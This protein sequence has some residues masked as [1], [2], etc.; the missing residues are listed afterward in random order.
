MAGSMVLG[1]PDLSSNG[2]SNPQ[3]NLSLPEGIAFD[4]NGNLWVADSGNCRVVEF[5][6]P[7]SNGKPVNLIIGQPNSFNGMCDV[8]GGM[9]RCPMLVAMDGQGDLFVSDCFAGL[10]EFKPPL[11]ISS[12]PI[13]IGTTADCSPGQQPLTASDICSAAGLAFDPAGNLWVADAGSDF[14]SG[15]GNRIVRLPPPFTNGADTVIG[16]GTFSTGSNDWCPGN[17]PPGPNQTG[18]NS[19]A[20]IALDGTFNLYVAD[21]NNS[22]ALQF[23]PTYTLNPPPPHFVWQDGEAAAFV[24]GQPNFNTNTAPTPSQDGISAP[25]AVLAP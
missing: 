6:Q 13:P 23:E 16:Q 7:F 15:K 12:A 24:F 11:T 8:L 22:R 17:C 4:S 10:N 19:P 20:G 3:N 1:Q 14:G 25:V 2:N 5:T 18:L 21:L 9:L